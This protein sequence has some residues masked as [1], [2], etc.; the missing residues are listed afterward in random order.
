MAGTVAGAAEAAGKSIVKSSLPP[1]QKAGIVIAS[2][3]AGAG[4]HL[5]SSNLNKVISSNKTTGSYC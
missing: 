3:V 4:I 1:V 2:G 5:I